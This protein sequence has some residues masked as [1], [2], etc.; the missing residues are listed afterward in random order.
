MI[1]NYSDYVADWAYQTE[2]IGDALDISDV[3]DVR[4][5]DLARLKNVTAW[6]RAVSPSSMLDDSIEV[7][8]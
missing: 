1:R 8:Y 4:I 6:M 5:G 7:K 3:S 2:L